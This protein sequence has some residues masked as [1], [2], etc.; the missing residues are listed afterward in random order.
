MKPL[1]SA[2]QFRDGF[3][4]PWTPG[5]VRV[6]LRTRVTFSVLEVATQIPL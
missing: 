1:G 3:Y 5:G 6:R 4:Q 2:V